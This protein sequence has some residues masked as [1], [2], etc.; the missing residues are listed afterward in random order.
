M[1]KLISTI[2]LASIVFIGCAEKPEE[3]QLLKKADN[4]TIELEGTSY[5]YKSQTLTSISGKVSE[6]KKN[7]GDYVNKGDIIF[8]I[9]QKNVRRE[10]KQLKFEIK[11]LEKNLKKYKQYNNNGANPTIIHLARINLEKV[12][13][14]Y[15]QGYASEE[16]FDEAKNRYANVL[17]SNKREENSNSKEYYNIEQNIISKKTKLANLEDTIGDTTI[18]S[19]INGYISKLNLYE[20]KILS[21]G[22]NIGTIVDISRIRVKS[23][24]APGLLPFVKKDKEVKITFL[25]TPAIITTVPVKKVIPIIDPE[26]GRILVEFEV[27]NEH[28]I[29]QPGTKSI[30]SVLLSKEEKEKVNFMFNNGEKNQ[31]TIKAEN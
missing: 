23:G 20:G 22:E 4:L 15:S 17:F 1:T 16:K 14:L 30:A 25:T 29:I 28:N 2:A 7:T 24:L 18:K 8:S 10:I 6:I 26:F 13:K 3:R 9:D 21:E 12:A 19:N 11:A 27:P 5:A 31:L